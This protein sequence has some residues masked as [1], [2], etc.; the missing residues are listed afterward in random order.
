MRDIE[1]KIADLRQ[2][3]DYKQKKIA[4]KLKVEEDTYSKWERGVNDMPLTKCNELANFFGVS[5][6]Y[7]LNLTDTNFIAERNTVDVML[8]KT[9]LLDLRKKHKL[10]QGKLSNELGFPQR[11]YSNYENGS[12][13]P[14]T[15]KIYYIAQYYQ[16][17]FDYLVGRTDNR[18][19]NK[20]TSI[21]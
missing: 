2:D 15:F 8:L 5:I 1:T 16:V 21:V 17:S 19:L 4:E 6:D 7:M 13:I 11:T 14:T 18:S 12:S 10:S 20:E 3:K 9:R